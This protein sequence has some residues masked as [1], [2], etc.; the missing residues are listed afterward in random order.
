MNRATKSGID[1]LYHAEKGVTPI[2]IELEE[3]SDE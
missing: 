3:L 1:Y 2:I